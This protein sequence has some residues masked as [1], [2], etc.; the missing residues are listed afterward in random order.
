[1]DAGLDFALF[2][3][4]ANLTYSEESADM[5]TYV[6]EVLNDDGLILTEQ[7]IWKHLPGDVSRFFEPCEKNAELLACE[8]ALKH[9][10]TEI[11]PDG[12]EERMVSGVWGYNED[13]VIIYRKNAGVEAIP[14]AERGRPLA[15][16]QVQQAP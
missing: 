15:D 2:M 8:G 16:L 10:L 13:G 14:N 11:R 6:I 9:M 12:R 1:M 7:D 3:A 5:R 4:S